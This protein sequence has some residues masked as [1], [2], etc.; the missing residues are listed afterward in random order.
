MLEHML[1]YVHLFVFSLSLCL[2]NSLQI[3]KEGDSRTIAANITKNSA[4]EPLYITATAI[5][6]NFVA[7]S[8]PDS[9]N[10]IGFKA[11][12]WKNIIF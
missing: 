10:G 11:R 3:F 8:P 1:L 4:T 9:I 7:H 6:I 12:F 2:S 5:S